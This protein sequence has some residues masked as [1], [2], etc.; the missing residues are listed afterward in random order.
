MIELGVEVDALESNQ[1]STEFALVV[2]FKDFI[3]RL[4]LRP[5]LLVRALPSV[6]L[7]ERGLGVGSLHLLSVGQ[8]YA[9]RAKRAKRNSPLLGES[10]TLPL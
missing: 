9:H 8:I 5:Q 7:L 4:D 2:H 1:G 3:R 6:L 10:P